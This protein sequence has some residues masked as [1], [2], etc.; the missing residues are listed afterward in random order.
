MSQ[1]DSKCTQSLREPIKVTMQK[2][3]ELAIAQYEEEKRQETLLDI[4]IKALET[5]LE[6]IRNRKP[7]EEKA[8]LKSKLENLK[9][10]IEVTQTQYNMTQ[11]ENLLLRGKIDHM[12]IVTASTKT[13]VTSLENDIEKHNFMSKLRTSMQIKERNQEKE[14][15]SEIRLVMS[16]SSNDKIRFTKKLETISEIIKQEKYNNTQTL[17]KQNDNL[18][19][20]LNKQLTVLD[21]TKVL[22]KLLGK[23]DFDVKSLNLKV[24]KKKQQNSKLAEM[25]HYIKSNSEA[26][27]EEDFVENFLNYYENTAKM[28]KYLLEVLAEIDSLEYSNKKFEAGLEDSTNFLLS[29]RSKAAKIHSELNQNMKKTY[30]MINNAIKH[31]AIIKDQL[32]KT[33]VLMIESQKLKKVLGKDQTSSVSDENLNIEEQL[34][35]V[36][37]FIH[38]LR[39]YKLITQQEEFSIRKITKTPSVL[40]RL[41]PEIYMNEFMSCK[42]LVEEF[43]QDEEKIPTP[44]EIM[45]ERARVLIDMPMTDRTKTPT[46]RIVGNV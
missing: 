36:E 25:M 35:N 1:F 42:D 6:K 33:R 3:I 40:R 21:N 28:S 30:E 22:Q 41:T 37:E 38:N 2:D 46:P 43:N 17:K 14:K 8:D 10:K 31:Q 12:R 11:N 26:S 5:D 27:D 13:K 23:L 34:A 7:D 39:I 32:D 9:K 24:S 20:I 16:K 19:I 45:R 18:D 29:S 15:A 4:G 44:I